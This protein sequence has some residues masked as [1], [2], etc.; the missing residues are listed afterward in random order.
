MQLDWKAAD[1][2]L[3]GESW[4][5]S[6]IR[7]H[8][9]TLCL[10]IGER[11]ASSEGERRATEYVEGRFA[12]WGLTAARRDEFPLQT[13]ECVSAAAEVVQTGMK[14]DLVPFHFCPEVRLEA[15]I[16]DVGYGTPYELDVARPSL[17][18]TAAVVNLAYEPFTPPRPL[19]DRLRDLAHCGATAAMVVETKSGRR[20]EFHNGT[21]WR[22]EQPQQLPLPT[23]TTSREHGAELR[24]Q[25]AQGHTLR[26]T[27]DSRFYT[28]TGLNVVAELEGE[29]WPEQTL[30]LGGHHDTVRGTPGG[31]DNA[32]GICVALEAARVLTELKRE[33]GQGPGCTIRFATWS[34]EEQGFQGSRAFVDKY[35]G[36]AG[37]VAPRLALNLDE[38]ATGTIKGLVLAFPHLRKLIQTTMDKL[39]DGYQC[40]VMSQ[41]DASS[42]HF[43]FLRQGF[44]AAHC[45]RWRFHGR[46]PDADFHHEAGDTIDKVRPRELQEYVAFLARLLLH[47]SWVSPQEWPPSPVNVD[48]VA[49]RLEAERGQVVRV[50]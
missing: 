16:T 5:G 25:A 44:D 14:L 11:W 38:L 27:V 13:W 32:T 30:V 6:Q 29:A 23:V 9:N 40:Q 7:N 8:L 46:H 48:Q 18:G 10:E 2:W 22:D 31:N 50:M 43:P 28:G 42:D 36:G 39:A 12:E 1:R 4:V 20:M 15:P 35:Y 37:K 24:R 45:W 17:A 34:A 41:L 47:L 49:Q 33:L 19:P 3:V 21:D 26:L